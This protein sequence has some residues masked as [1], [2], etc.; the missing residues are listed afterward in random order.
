M[1]ILKLKDNSLTEE[2]C[3]L[4]AKYLSD[5]CELKVFDISSNFIKDEGAC[6]ILSATSHVSDLSLS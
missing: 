4:L 6:W 5:A 3:K 1:E 2:H